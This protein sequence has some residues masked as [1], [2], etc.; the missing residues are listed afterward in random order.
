[1]TD[2]QLL[3]DTAGRVLLERFP[4]S[5]LRAGLTDDQCHEDCV[6]DLR[7]RAGDLGWYAFLVPG[8]LGGGSLGGHGIVDA[9]LIAGQRGR[10][11]AP[12]PFTDMHVAA[13]SISG[14]GTAGQ[15]EAVLPDLASGEHVIACA[16]G[17]I[18][19]SP[20][21]APVELTESP[22]GV[23]LNG[24]ARP[25]SYPA[26]ASTL[27]VWVSDAGRVRRFLVPADAEGLR[28]RPLAGLDLTAR[29]G[30]VTFTSVLVPRSAEL[31]GATGAARADLAVGALLT[32]AD[33]AGAM[34]RLLELTVEYAR[35]R[36]AFGRVI[37]SFQAVKHQIADLSML[38]QASKA[39]IGA[40]TEAIAGQHPDA[41]E[42]ASIAKAFV[43]EQSQAVGQ[44]CLQ[45]H[46]GIGYAWE[47]DLHLYLRR[48]A[49]NGAAYGSASMHRA[50]IAESHLGPAPVPVPVP[51]TGEAG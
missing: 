41:T 25:V 33:S 18:L 30:V 3:E 6:R 28:I 23:V 43:S 27:L 17:A 2:L 31:A 39:V 32:A 36:R 48:L 38:V 51:A 8:E 46:G 4:V 34:D 49:A 14:S 40:A 24:Q 50:L 21:C 5:R 15:R 1:M 12:G 11:L 44:G 7:K 35:E 9:A 10:H 22:D 13:A 16:F 26:A 20:Q 42:I 19:A 37:G 47:H 45:L 29:A